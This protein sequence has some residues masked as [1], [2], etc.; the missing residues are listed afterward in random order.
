MRFFAILFVLGGLLVPRAAAAVE[1]VGTAV[2]RTSDWVSVTMR[3][4]D[5]FSD[6]IESITLGKPTLEDVFIA[7]TGHR[8]WR[9]RGAE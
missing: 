7:R 8:F 6:R 3:V 5:A 2:A 1:V 9:D 4:D